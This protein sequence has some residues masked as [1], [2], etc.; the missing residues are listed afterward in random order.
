MN[1]QRRHELER[2]VLADKLGDGYQKAQPA[3]KPIL[4][5]AVVLLLGLLGYQVIKGN[6]SR[7]SAEKWSEFYFAREGGNAELFAQLGEE[8]GNKPTGI[9]AK[10][11]AAQGYLR[12]GVEALYVNRKEGVENIR[13]AIEL[14]K[15]LKSSDISELKAL[16]TLGLAQAHESLGEL[17]E[18]IKNYQV[19]AD[20]PSASDEQK[21]RLNDQIAFLKSADAKNFYEWFNKIDPKPAASPIFS[22]DLNLPP[23]NPSL[24]L[25]PNNL[26][27][28]GNPVVP[29]AS[30][31]TTPIAPT[32]TPAVNPPVENKPVTPTEPTAATTPTNP[33]VAT[34]AAP[35]AETPTPAA[36]PTDPATTPAATPAATP[37]PSPATP[38]EKPATDTPA[39]TEPK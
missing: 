8:F 2:N 7:D 31:P 27:N 14:W 23:T 13:K 21:R 18:A 17:D 24:S 30:N 25:D 11:S 10:H 38:P 39:P 9:W 34:P 3:L 36:P 12:D 19:I 32:D 37:E 1:N 28:L 20:Q 22:G 35:P 16:A 33:P 6:S 26:P 5:V 4:V 15:P 29:P